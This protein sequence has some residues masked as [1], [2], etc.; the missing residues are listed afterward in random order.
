MPTSTRARLVDAAFALFE[1]QG[2][3]ETTVEEIT[4]RAGTGRTTFF[5]HF[6]GKEDVVFP[7]H[8]LLLPRVEARLATATGTTR[9]VALREA[10]RI[11]LDH[12]L[13]EG[14]T[15][16]ARYRL[17]RTVSSLRDREDASAQRYLRLFRQQISTWIGDEPDGA[18]RAE[19]LAA[20]VITAHN[21]VLRRWLREETDDVD[22]AFDAA[23][24]RA[25][26]GTSPTRAVSSTVVVHTGSPDVE[27]VLREVRRALTPHD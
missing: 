10:A 12:Y 25:L 19:L 2:F 23:L 18:L 11:V 3:H 1:E 6:R 21:H 26:S 24:A 9:E 8:D 14:A 22:A 13:E 7:D 20:A 5:R 15:A 17:T 4:A 27:Q 16:R